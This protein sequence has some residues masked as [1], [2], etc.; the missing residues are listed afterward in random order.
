MCLFFFYVIEDKD[1]VSGENG[2]EEEGV[3]MRMCE[4]ISNEAESED[5]DLDTV[6]ARASLDDSMFTVYCAIV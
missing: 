2:S 6:T 3:C 4:P 1:D 5:A